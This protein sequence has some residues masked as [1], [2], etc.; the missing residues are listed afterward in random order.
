[1]SGIKVQCYSGYRADERPTRFYLGEK[2]LQVRDIEDQWYSPH[3][4][5]FRIRASDGNIYIIRHDETHDSWSLNAFRETKAEK[6]KEF[7]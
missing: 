5:Y 1:M 3:A 7:L 6:R 2:E 4:R